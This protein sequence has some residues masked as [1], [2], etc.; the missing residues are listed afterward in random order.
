MILSGRSGAI[1]MTAGI[2]AFG[3]APILAPPFTGYDPAIFPVVIARP[4]IQPAGYAFAIWGLIYGWLAVHGLVAG[5]ARADQPAWE[6]HRLALTVSV[7][8]GAGWLFIAPYY[9]VLATIVILIMA[10]TALAAFL[11]APTTPDRW[12][13]SAPTAIY[14]GWLTAACSV[15][16]GVVLAGYGWLSDTASALVMLGLVLAGAIYIQSRKPAMPVYG[17]T[18]VWAIIGIVVV[19]WAD[20]TPVAYAAVAGAV[21]MTAATAFLSL[22]R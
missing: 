20:N 6:G 13:L 22:R 4:A 7:V 2:V 8:L 11:I 1:V 10:A 18:V 17:A 9:P 5:I 12:L 21:V 15:S 3:L 16:T 19:N 14:A